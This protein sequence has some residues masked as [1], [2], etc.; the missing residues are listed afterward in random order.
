MY[1]RYNNLIHQYESTEVTEMI[2]G[3]LIQL[4]FFKKKHMWFR[5]VTSQLR[6]FLMVHPL[7]KTVLDPPLNLLC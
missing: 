6:H 2:Y 7:P 4:V 5:Q 1:R 3:F